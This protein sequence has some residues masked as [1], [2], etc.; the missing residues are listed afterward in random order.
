MTLTNYGS[1]CTL[2]GCSA[3]EFELP[4]STSAHTFNVVLREDDQFLTP[5]GRWEFLYDDEQH[6]L[7]N[8]MRPPPLPVPE[9]GSEELRPLEASQVSTASIESDVLPNLAE[10]KTTDGTDPLIDDVDPTPSTIK[11]MEP[12]NQ[13]DKVIGPWLQDI[14]HDKEAV[15]SPKTPNKDST[16]QQLDESAAPAGTTLTPEDA[17]AVIAATSEEPD[18][19]PRSNG[20]EGDVDL[21]LGTPVIDGHV[22][23]VGRRPKSERKSRVSS[24][25]SEHNLEADGNTAVP[26]ADIMSEPRPLIQPSTE[27]PLSSRKRRS[28]SQ[29]RRTSPRKRMRSEGTLSDQQRGFTSKLIEET[30]VVTPKTPTAEAYAQRLT[31]TNTSRCIQSSV[32]RRSTLSSTEAFSASQLPIV[33]MAGTTTVDTNSKTTKAFEQLGGRITKDIVEAT[34]LCVPAPP[35]T[36][37]GTFLLSICHGKT[38]VIESWIEDSVKKGRFRKMAPYLPKDPQREQEWGFNLQ[39][40]I[41][42]GRAGLTHILQ[43]RTIYFTKRFHGS[44]KDKLIDEFS[45][46]ATALGAEEVKKMTP[47]KKCM[48]EV[49]DIRATIVIGH[50]E[51]DPDANKITERG[52]PLYHKDLLIMAVLRGRLDLEE[53]V[54]VAV[55]K[56]EPV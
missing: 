35:L 2:L 11:R 6:T 13:A 36:K 3:L 49:E 50:G 10:I 19:S 37:T 33:Y 54:H 21:D 34:V 20:N 15:S 55:V 30:I 18:Q 48:N 23:K 12:E 22:V 25:A 38:I 45:K 43:G 53:F 1:Q 24:S 39:E 28:T 40:A 27:A 16:E 42:R 14:T 8:S 4:K 46:V 5:A 9:G 47:S 41:E 52:I 51:N 56:E 29:T 26:S 7:H 44:L 32:R 17:E 31:K